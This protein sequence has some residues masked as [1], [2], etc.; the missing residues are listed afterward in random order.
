MGL[1]LTQVADTDHDTV[2]LWLPGGGVVKVQAVSTHGCKVKVAYD[3]PADVKIYRTCV[4]DA[5][6][7]AR[8]TFPGVP[9][10]GAIDARGEGMQ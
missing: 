8:P 6:R 10:L 2:E 5:I 3:A 4:A 9:V 1:V 7:K